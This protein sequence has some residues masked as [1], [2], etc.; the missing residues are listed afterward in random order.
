MCNVDTGLY[1]PDPFASTGPYSLTISN[2]AFED[3]AGHALSLY[4][5]A[6]SGKKVNDVYRRSYLN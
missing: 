3:S 6:A 4:P 1:P 2:A 5:N